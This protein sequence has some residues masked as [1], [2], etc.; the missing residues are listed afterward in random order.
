[1]ANALVEDGDGNILT[2]KRWDD[3]HGDLKIKS[4]IVYNNINTEGNL[5]VDGSIESKDS[6]T[7]RGNITSEGNI[8]S[9]GNVT[10]NNNQ[11]LVSDGSWTKV[12]NPSNLSQY[13][14]GVG[15][16]HLSAE[17]NVYTSNLCLQG[18]YSCHSLEDIVDKLEKA[19][20]MTSGHVKLYRDENCNE[21]K[22]PD[23]VLPIGAYRVNTEEDW[24]AIF[25][26]DKTP[27]K[28]TGLDNRVNCVIGSSNVEYRI[29]EH[30][31]GD[32]RNTGWRTGKTTKSDLSGDARKALDESS[33]IEIRCTQF[34]TI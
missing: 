25:D 33:G 31:V 11:T 27:K 24:A 17:E 12:R 6:I 2:K 7:S 23:K 10:V 30:G 9:G 1:M 29:W 18:E 34:P 3:P 4:I 13:K 5:Y 19:Y 14:G 20:C 8:T 26:I 16:V 21:N 32:G 28:D 22:T 15:A